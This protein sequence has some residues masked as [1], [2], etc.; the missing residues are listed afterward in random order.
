MQFFQ[1]LARFRMM[2]NCHKLFISAIPRAQC[3][4]LHKRLKAADQSKTMSGRYSH[5]LEK[6]QMEEG[7]QLPFE[8]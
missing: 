7:L 1:S 2:Q 4:K 3:T 5:S 8:Q 6:A